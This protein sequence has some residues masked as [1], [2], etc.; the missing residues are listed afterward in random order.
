MKTTDEANYITMEG[1]QILAAR[2]INSCLDVD[3]KLKHGLFGLASEAGEV[4]GIYQKAYQGHA[5]D[6]EKL[7]KELGDVLWMVAEICT[8]HGYSL[9][10]IAS[11]NINKLRKRYPDG[12]SADRS[13]NRNEQE[14][15]VNADNR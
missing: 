8:A 12:F 7:K 9:G 6:S 10:E 13:V 14:E 11:M 2:T 4:L 5:I 3:E 1:Y 15:N